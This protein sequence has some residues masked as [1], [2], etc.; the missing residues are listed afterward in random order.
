LGGSQWAAGNDKTHNVPGLLWIDSI[1][2]EWTSYL[3]RNKE[4]DNT[5][6]VFT[7]DHGCVAKGHC[8]EPSMR[9][10]M[11]LH[12][13]NLIHPT[14]PGHHGAGS[15]RV[16]DAVVAN[17]DLAPTLLDATGVG[18]AWLR[19]GGQRIVDGRS[20]L[21][22][23]APRHARF[24]P[25]KQVHPFGIFCEIYS[26][27]SLVGPNFTLVDLSRSHYTSAP[28]DRKPWNDRV[29][30]YRHDDFEQKVNLMAKVGKHEDALAS[31]ALSSLQQHLNEHLRDTAPACQHRFFASQ[32][33]TV[34]TAHSAAAAKKEGQQ[35]GGGRRLTSLDPRYVRANETALR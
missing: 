32:F 29:Q 9:V 30:L 21:P 4:L 18:E 19:Q 13:P 10:P 22:L 7:A 28:Y 20:L 15:G 23:V 27:R 34:L 5:L 35:G 12:C 1:V 17:I 8:F 11:F 25:L 24:D 2:G 33:P 31:H 26:D 3:E 14:T 16:V 6:I